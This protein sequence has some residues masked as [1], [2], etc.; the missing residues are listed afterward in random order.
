MVLL[1]FAV[2]SLDLQV[3]SPAPSGPWTTSAFASY[4]Q[5]PLKSLIW[6]LCSAHQVIP[7]AS[8]TPVAIDVTRRVVGTQ[9]GG[10]APGAGGGASSCTA[11][12]P[13]AAGSGVGSGVSRSS[14]TFTSVTS[15]AGT[16][17]LI[18]NGA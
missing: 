6:E 9:A 8:A 15:P 11:G 7:A 14:F 18:T 17:T 10:R 16:D 1:V 5:E 4:W 3:G 13:A 2:S 12:A